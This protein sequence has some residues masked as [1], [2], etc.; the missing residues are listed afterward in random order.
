MINPIVSV[1]I[2]VYNTKFYLKEALDSL[3][4]QKEY[5]YEIIIINDGS[6]DGSGDFLEDNYGKQNF[7]KIIHTENHGQGHARNIG[8]KLAISKFI[9][10]FDSDDIAAPDLF[11]T[12]YDLINSKPNLELF[13]FS[14][15]SFLDPVISSQ[16]LSR[17]SELSKNTF[18]RNII[19]EC[20]SGEEAFRLL[21]DLNTFSPV[22]WLYIFSRKI[23][24]KSKLQFS[25]FKYEDEEFT[26]TLFLW[27]GK[28]YISNDILFQRRVRENST[29]QLRRTYKD[30]KGY[31]YTIEK[32]KQLKSLDF[33][34]DKTKNYLDRRI[35]TFIKLIIE[36]KATTNPKL[37]KK[38][39]KEYNSNLSKL[40]N[41]NRSLFIF[42]IRFPLEYRLRK[43]K[44]KLFN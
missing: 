40:I 41:K 36:L 13:C 39:K 9:Y 29:M 19:K 37:N 5:I 28:T 35:N 30:F 17:P 34:H 15:D 23:L 16:K 22:P 26:H 31:F 6:T 12:F 32:I 11:K 3:L 10:F 21:I 8:I 18:K 44:K 43:L 38:E 2:P 25:S 27:A 33:L 24:D 20:E 42:R 4:V 14:A 7:V 1:I